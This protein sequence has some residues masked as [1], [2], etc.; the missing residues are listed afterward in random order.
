MYFLNSFRKPNPLDDAALI[1]NYKKFDDKLALEE[2]FQRYNHL[3]FS[4]C[5]KYLKNPEESQDAVMDIFAKLVGDL[6]S[7][8]IANFKSWLYIVTKN[9]CRMKMRQSTPEAPALQKYSEIE[10]LTGENFELEILNRI[11]ERALQRELYLALEQLDEPQRTCIQLFYF[12]EKSYREIAEITKFGPK[13]VKS[14]IQNGKRNLQ[15]ILLQR[16]ALMDVE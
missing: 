11:D 16:K 7:Y 12:D 13:Q 8:E 6:K 10:H 9:Y 2:L 1:E 5:R 4:V 15:R 3:V 14:C